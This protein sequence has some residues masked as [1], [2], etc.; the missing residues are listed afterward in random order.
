ME[1]TFESLSQQ[2]VKCGTHRWLGN[3]AHLEL[4]TN[5]LVLV[6]IWL[7]IRMNLIF[8]PQPLL[9]SK[10]YRH[11]HAKYRSRGHFLQTRSHLHSSTSA[12][13]MYFTDVL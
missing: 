11:Q 6:N 13:L 8:L 1:N 9:A 5:Y 4:I 3:E 10:C 2:K 12:H 7:W